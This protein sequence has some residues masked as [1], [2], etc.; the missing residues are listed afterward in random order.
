MVRVTYGL[1]VTDEDDD[2][3]TLFAEALNR[4]IQEGTPG[5][6]PVDLFPFRE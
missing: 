6:C 4:V 5:L 3:F 1:D 2:F